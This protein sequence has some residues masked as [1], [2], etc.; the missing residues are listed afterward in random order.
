[1]IIFGVAILMLNQRV[2]NS[3]KQFTTVTAKPRRFR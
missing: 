1:M 2:T 3:R